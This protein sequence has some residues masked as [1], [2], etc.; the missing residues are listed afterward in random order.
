MATINK[1]VCDRCGE[2]IK[3]VGWTGI[4]KKIP[5]RLYLLELFNGNPDGYSYSEFEPELCSACVK[6]FHNWFNGDKPQKE[7][8]DNG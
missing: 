4:L 3:Y 5:K 1:K 8:A 7:G 6:S 2:E